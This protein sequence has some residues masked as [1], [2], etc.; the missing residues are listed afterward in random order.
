MEKKKIAEQISAIADEMTAKMCEE[1]RENNT[2]DEATKLYVRMS[3][4]RDLRRQVLVMRGA[5]QAE[6]AHFDRVTDLAAIGIIDGQQPDHAI[7][8]AEKLATGK[9]VGG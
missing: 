1:Y 2:P 3:I 6:L 4:T 8:D 9:R 5:G 7:D